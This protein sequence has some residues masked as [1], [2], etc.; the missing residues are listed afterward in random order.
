VDARELIQRAIWA[1]V[2]PHPMLGQAE[3]CVDM[4]E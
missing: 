3:A 4:E 2:E 1:R